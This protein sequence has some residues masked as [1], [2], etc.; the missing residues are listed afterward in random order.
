MKWWEKILLSDSPVIVLGKT[1]GGKTTAVLNFVDKI[2]VSADFYVLDLFGEYVE[3]NLPVVKPVLSF[4]AVK[5]YLPY[6]LSGAL[7]PSSSGLE[8]AAAAEEAT[9]VSDS[10][11]DFF[12]NLEVLRASRRYYHGVQAILSRLLPIQET[13]IDE[14]LPFPPPS[15]IDLSSI[16]RLDSKF[17]FQAV[18]TAWFTAEASV[19]EFPRET[20]LVIEEASEQHLPSVTP[21]ILSSLRLLRKHKVRPI[22]VY[23]TLPKG[24]EDVLLEQCL[25]ILP[26]GHLAEQYFLKYSFP[27]DILDLK[28]GEALLYVPEEGKWRRVKIKPKVYPKP[29]KPY[30]VSVNNCSIILKAKVNSLENNNAVDK[31][32]DSAVSDVNEKLE[33]VEKRLSKIEEKLASIR[34]NAPDTLSSKIK[35]AVDE[36]EKIKRRV[37]ADEKSIERL[38]D[39]VEEYDRRIQR[40]ERRLSRIESVL[41]KIVEYLEYREQLKSIR[42]EEL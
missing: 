13:L 41:E 38:L 11:I 17:I 32:T 35:A 27:K 10:W 42:G 23:H 12:K 39:F 24:Y 3:L 31:A 33:K 40:I 30:I 14:D 15:I 8:I 1:G 36:I 34:V 4:R 28:V 37:A 25:L 29:K 6:V 22:L 7:R 26:L 16:P 21:V 2:K 5:R 18:F 19:R 20:F 9:A